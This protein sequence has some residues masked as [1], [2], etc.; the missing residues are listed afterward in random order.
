[1]SKNIV[2]NQTSQMTSQ[3]GAYALRAT[4][5]RLYARM[6]THTPTR[7]GTHMHARTLKPAH[8]DQYVI[9][10]AYPQQ[11]WF[12]ERALKLRYTYIACLVTVYVFAQ[13]TCY[14]PILWPRHPGI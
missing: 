7:P 12:R 4:L 14:G 10:T 2:E 9:L 13:V 1:M 11:Q 6:G 8:T 3:Y 5:A